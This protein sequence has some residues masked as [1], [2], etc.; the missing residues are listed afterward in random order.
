ML[1]AQ[2]CFVLYSLV[3]HMPCK[4]SQTN[5]STQ[6]PILI[7]PCCKLIDK[8]EA[9]YSS[10]SLPAEPYIWRVIREEGKCASINHNLEERIC[11][12]TS[13]GC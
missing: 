3:Q 8:S 11:R 7:A 5:D 2:G 10:F 13:S 6:Q 12:M 1:L 4:C 9:M